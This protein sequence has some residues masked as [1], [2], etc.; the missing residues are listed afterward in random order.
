MH[1]LSIY[2]FWVFQTQPFLQTAETIVLGDQQQS[3]HSM[4]S[5][6]GSLAA[7]TAHLD[8][9]SNVESIDL[10]QEP[11]PVQYTI[12]R[13]KSCDAYIFNEK[14]MF[15]CGVISTTFHWKIVINRWHIFQAQRSEQTRFHGEPQAVLNMAPNYVPL[16]VSS[17]QFN[18][19][20]TLYAMEVSRMQCGQVKYFNAQE[21]NEKNN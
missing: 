9:F 8:Q 1:N 6:G 21:G 19:F 16:V 3:T 13:T 2:S 18:D 15:Y 20:E 14:D 10:P 5:T 17:S 11:P 4:T 7:A 12:Y